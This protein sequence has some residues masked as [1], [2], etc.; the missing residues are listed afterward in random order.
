MQT[1]EEILDEATHLTEG[2]RRR[3]VA[4]LQGENSESPSVYRRKNAMNRWLARAGS[5]H[6]DIADV[7]S[8]KNQYLT[9]ISA[10]DS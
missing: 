8:N 2:E 3:L 6:A 10:T 9:E 5:G 1:V 7:S 4:N